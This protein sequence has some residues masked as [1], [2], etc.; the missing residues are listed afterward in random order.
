MERAEKILS[1]VDFNSKSPSNF[2][3]E[4]DNRNY[5][6]AATKA[7]LLF[8]SL[9]DLRMQGNVSLREV[10]PSYAMISSWAF[11]GILVHRVSLMAFRI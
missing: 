4:R 6:L 3:V 1:V 5:H 2:Q 10:L 7:C 9:L 8:L 11:D